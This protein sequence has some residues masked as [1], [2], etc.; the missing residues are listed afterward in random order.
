[1]GEALTA[2]AGS[3]V[4]LGDAFRSWEAFKAADGS[5]SSPPN[6]SAML[7]AK[8]K[9]TGFTVKRDMAGGY[10]EGVELLNVNSKG[11]F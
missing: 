5:Y 3:K 4:R 11:V 2:K 8:L 6:S 10:I 1:M 9:E 7:S